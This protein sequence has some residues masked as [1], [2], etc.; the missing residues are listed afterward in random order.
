QTLQRKRTPCNESAPA[1]DC[2]P[3]GQRGKRRRSPRT[4]LRTHHGRHG[5]PLAHL[6]DRA[7]LRGKPKPIKNSAAV[8]PGAPARFADARLAQPSRP[9][10]VPP[11][12]WGIWMTLVLGILVIFLAVVAVYRRVDVR[13]AL[14]VAALA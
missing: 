3:G 10:A 4:D 14:L 7:V 12:T 13:L 1:L 11:V 5:P 9:A 8:L 6:S 2:A